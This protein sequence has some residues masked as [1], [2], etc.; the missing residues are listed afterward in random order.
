M[1]DYSKLLGRITEKFGSQRSFAR[2]YGVSENTISKKLNGKMGITAADIIKM[3]DEAY[4]DIK[5]NEIPTYF[6]KKKVQEN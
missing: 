1:F 5:P 4:L 3:S 6:F 2:A